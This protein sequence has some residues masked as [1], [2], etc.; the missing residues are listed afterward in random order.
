MH[1]KISLIISKVLSGLFVNGLYLIMYS[2]YKVA[3]NKWMIIAKN[4]QL[5]RKTSA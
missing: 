4:G 3:V 5:V 1:T 2:A